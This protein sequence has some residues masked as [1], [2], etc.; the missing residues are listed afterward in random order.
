MKNVFIVNNTAGGGKFTV[1]LLPQIESYFCD[2][3]GEYII[4]PTRCVGHATEIA[5]KYAQLGEPVRIYACGGDGTLHEVLNGIVGFDN[6]EL[7]AFPCGT[8]N[9]YVASFGDRDLFMNVASQVGGQSVCVDVIS[10][11][12]QYSLNQCSMGFDA[13]VADNV[14]RFKGKKHISGSMA[15]LLA[16][17][18]TLGGKISN[19]LTVSVD[20]GEEM[21]GE[22]LFA[23]SAKGKYQGGGIM[24]APSASP[25]SRMLNFMIV[26][27]VSK[28]RFVTLLPKYMKGRHTDIHDIVLNLHGRKMTVKAERKLPVT[29]DGEVVFADLL[30]TEIVPSAVKF[31]LP[32]ELADKF[33]RHTRVKEAVS[34]GV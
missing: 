7:G 5:R 12:G 28:P 22:F 31:I 3:G 6:V 21:E 14:I 15:Y 20:D 18:D 17:L 33:E 4:E 8:G 11:A 27:K 29:L 16:I 24:S 23:I 34:A 19:R 26:R 10:A 1:S 2:N 30:V 32:C 25:V 13:A 9:D